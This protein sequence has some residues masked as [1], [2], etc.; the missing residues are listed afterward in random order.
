MILHFN[1]VAPQIFFRT[2]KFAVDK[3][4]AERQGEINVETEFKLIC[5]N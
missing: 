1:F 4:I 3:W 2:R 5:E